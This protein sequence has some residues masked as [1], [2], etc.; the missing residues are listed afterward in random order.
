M[1]TGRRFARKGSGTCR[2]LR[3][4]AELSNDI[5]P[6]PLASRTWKK[7]VLLWGKTEA[8]S[9]LTVDVKAGQEH[10][11]KGG[12]SLGLIVGRP[13]LTVVPNET[14]LQEISDCKLLLKPGSTATQ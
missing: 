8:R 1:N 5:L 6:R 14:A 11:I 9:S 12:L 3:G 7:K 13:T 4:H 10:F 2:P